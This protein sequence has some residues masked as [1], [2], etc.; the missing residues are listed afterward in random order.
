MAKK[1][2][3]PV[4][5]QGDPDAD[6]SARRVRRARSLSSQ[7][8][9]GLSRQRAADF[10]VS[11]QATAHPALGDLATADPAT[12][13]AADSGPAGSDPT[14]GDGVHGPGFLI[15]AARSDQTADGFRNAGPD[16][17]WPSEGVPDPA[18]R[19]ASQPPFGGHRRASARHK[20]VPGDVDE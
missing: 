14:R 2:A 13:D 20:K 5:L 17:F 12:A 18:S 10:A 8:G 11:G 15:P 4:G 1:L 7:A 16:V 6:A 3:N 19:A 9:W